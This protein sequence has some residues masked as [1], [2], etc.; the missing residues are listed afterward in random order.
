MS[1]DPSQAGP[2][3]TKAAPPPG[4]P[5]DDAIARAPFAFVDIEMTGLGKAD[6]ILEICVERVVGDRV[7]DRLE[8]LVRPDDGRF[9][10]AHIHGITAEALVGAPVF[11][12][13]ADRVLELLRGAVFV[14]HAA[15]HDVGFL[16]AE[17][18]RLGRPFAV[19]FVV[20]TL[21]LA[22]RAFGF[23]S[24]SLEAL[25][26]ELS[27]DR[28]RGHRAADDVRLLRAVFAKLALALTPT[29]PRDLLGVRVGERIA[30]PVILEKLREA[31]K[32]GAAVRLRYRPA[33]KRAEELV[34]VVSRLQG[35]FSE[36][37]EPDGESRARTGKRLD[38]PLVFGYL[39]PGRGRRQLRA[40]R[41]LS[42]EPIG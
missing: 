13:V 10:N 28:G 9:G 24:H 14:A 11:A 36:A 1:G 5:W 37:N 41:I 19:P 22:R 23:P 7:E 18:A 29:T 26:K 8:T 4:S 25:S 31:A 3:D 30:R 38:P 27:L 17:L 6:R 39:L 42:I 34:M 15:W 32:T 12:D 2:T 40:D 20:D 16:E 21:A 35:D 33:G